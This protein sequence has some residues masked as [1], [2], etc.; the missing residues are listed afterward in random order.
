M[1]NGTKYYCTGSLYSDWVNVFA[2]TPDGKAASAI[3]PVTRPG[4][5]LKDD[6]DGIGQRLTGSGTGV[7]SDVQV[8]ADEVLMAAVE[9]SEVASLTD[10]ADPYPVGQ[11]CQLILTAIIAGVMRTVLHD[12]VA[13]V[14][15]R[16]RTYAH[17]AGATPA[18]DPLLQQIIG[19][20][21]AGAF[22]AE[23]V[24]LATAEAHGLAVAS[25]HHERADFELAHRGSLLAA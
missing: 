23:A 8:R 12:A 13:L 15:G 17:G 4:V 1:L 2:S 21:A 11:F 10:P 14:R 20:I 7:F 5:D 3:I 24:I 22:A 25:V 9:S 6:W 18:A 19:E 16:A